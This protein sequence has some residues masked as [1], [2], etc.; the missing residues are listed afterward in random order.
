MPIG[1]DVLGGLGGAVGGIIGLATMGKGGKDEL[2]EAIQ[3]WR[4]VQTPGYD[5][6]SLSPPQL[7]ILAEYF[8][9]TYEAQVPQEVKLAQEEGPEG[10]QAQAGAVQYLR[11]VQEEGL[12]LAE[13]LA[14]QEA[15]GR[16]AQEAR[17]QD[18]AVMQNLAA[19]GRLGGGTEAA[20]RA[21]R[22]QT[23]ANL[24]RGMGSDLA[25]QAVQNRYRAALDA[26]QAGGQLRAQDLE[27]ARSNADA[28]N[29]FNELTAQMR[30]QAA[31]DAME[32]R[33]QAQ[34]YNV[35]TRQRVGEENEL[36]RY[37]TQL[38]NLNRQNQ[39][40][41]Q[42][43]QDTVTKT[44]GLTGA[45]GGLSQAKYAEQ[46]A[47]LRNAQQ[48]GQGIGGAAGGAGGLLGLF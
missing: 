12:P 45:L 43:F 18:E 6:R 1:G 32:Q 27:K 40:R 46:E 14:A 17:S 48:I 19:R 44:T 35:G 26:G 33:A 41:G 24:A 30:T 25:S 29:R 10:R 3:L 47:R 39:L 9:E 20:L 13:R 38:E 2:K 23:A 7:R 34:A 15:Q 4:D 5:M 36:A 42:G 16:V 21:G 8:P 31:R 11:G 37:G 22:G 28:V